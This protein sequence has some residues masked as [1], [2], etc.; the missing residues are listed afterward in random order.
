MLRAVGDTTAAAR[1][2][3]LAAASPPASPDIDALD[4]GR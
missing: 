2:D 1:E 3:R 4:T